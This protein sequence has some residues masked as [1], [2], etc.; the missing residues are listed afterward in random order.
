MTSALGAFVFGR[1]LMNKCPLGGVAPSLELRQ[2]P[3]RAGVRRRVDSPEPGALQ[4]LEHRRE[5]GP[6]LA[7]ARSV[8]AVC[9][10]CAFG[11]HAGGVCSVVQGVCSMLTRD[12]VFVQGSLLAPGVPANQK[13]PRAPKVSIGARAGLI[14]AAPKVTWIRL[15]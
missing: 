13:N 7:C 8:H 6:R 9:I 14:L 5:C 4:L 15:R 11:V 10:R 2:W 3:P 1:L 12:G